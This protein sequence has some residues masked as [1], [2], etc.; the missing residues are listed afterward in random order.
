MDI[1]LAQQSSVQPSPQPTLNPP[2]SGVQQAGAVVAIVFAVAAGILG[3][4]ILRGGR[5]L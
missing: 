5:G 1:E 2:P 3:Y 4:K